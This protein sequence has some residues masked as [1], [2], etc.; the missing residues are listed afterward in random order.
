MTPTTTFKETM[1]YT[2]VANYFTSREMHENAFYFTNAATNR[3]V[4]DADGYMDTVFIYKSLAIA[5]DSRLFRELQSAITT[6]VS[7]S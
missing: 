1:K 5:G 3:N 6:Y 7:W 4:C 2:D